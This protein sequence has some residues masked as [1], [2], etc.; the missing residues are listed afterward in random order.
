LV[1][2]S[3]RRSV[4]QAGHHEGTVISMSDV[5]IRTSDGDLV[6]ADEVR[7]ITSSDGLRIVLVGGSQFI[8]AG[9]ESRPHTEKAA[10]ELAA[11][12]AE[13]CGDDA[14]VLLSVVRDERDW[15]V[16]TLPLVS[17]KVRAS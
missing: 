16:T 8:L 17:G 7:Q 14:A 6:R 2:E 10:Q 3:R 4:G 13:A 5:W 9:I 11:A 1:G 12:I 15:V